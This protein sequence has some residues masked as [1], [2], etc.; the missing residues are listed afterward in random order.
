MLPLQ[1]RGVAD[2]HRLAAAESLEMIEMLL[3]ELALAADAVERLQRPRFCDVSQKRDERLAFGEVTDAAERFDDERRIAQ[4][5]VA[6]IPRA[7]GPT[8]SGMLVVAAAM[9]A[10][11]SVYACSFRQS[12]DRR[13]GRLAN[14]GSAHDFAHARHPAIVRS[15]TRCAD[16]TESV[17]D[18]LP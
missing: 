18:G 7:F 14:V 9:M 8:A 1:V 2:A 16:S 4:P 10:P 5:A 11:V 6:V 3:D 17:S 13:T 12:A 15:R